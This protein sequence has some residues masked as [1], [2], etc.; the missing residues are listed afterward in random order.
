ENEADFAELFGAA[1]FEALL[2]DLLPP[3]LS[4][5]GSIELAV[6][7]GRRGV[8]TGLTESVV[9][10]STDE[11]LRPFGIGRVYAIGMSEITEAQFAASR[12]HDDSNVDRY[13][14]TSAAVSWY[15]AAQYC[16]WLSRQEGI[17]ED[18]W[19]YSGVEPFSEGM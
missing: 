10:E 18:Q 5:H 3:E 8:R 19:C 11:L 1:R 14:T 9:D 12:L 2:V 7:D 15:Q 6:I 13:S 16:N 4:D 17:P